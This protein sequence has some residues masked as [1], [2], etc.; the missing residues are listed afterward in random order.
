MML[1]R[2]VGPAAT[3]LCACRVLHAILRRR[4][5]PTV[6]LRYLKECELAAWV[7]HVTNCFPTTPANY[8]TSHLSCEPN[9][10]DFDS[11]HIADVPGEGIV[12][13]VRVLQ[14]EVYLGRGDADNQVANAG[15]IAEVSTLP[16]HRG[17]GYARRLLEKSVSDMGRAS[18]TISSLHSSKYAGYYEKL[19]WKRAETRF[20]FFTPN[21]HASNRAAALG[22]A[23]AG[24]DN[25]DDEDDGHAKNSRNSR[26]MHRS[27]SS[28]LIGP[29]RRKDEYWRRWLWPQLGS[30]LGL[31]DDDATEAVALAYR[32]KKEQ[33]NQR[34][35]GYVFFS[36]KRKKGTPPPSP[37]APAAHPR[38]TRQ[39]DIIIIAE[40]GADAKEV[41]YD[42]AQRERWVIANANNKAHERIQIKC[43]RHGGEIGS[44][45][46]CF[47]ALATA[48][49]VRKRAV[50]RVPEGIPALFRPR[51]PS[52]EQQSRGWER[53]EYV[54]RGYMYRSVNGTRGDDA[55]RH[56]ESLTARDSH[57]TFWVPDKF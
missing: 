20:L 23:A 41:E 47:E 21:T 9:G 17:K 55:Q 51:I 52:D 29:H 15:G 5:G 25:D 45:G 4:C 30:S 36:M 12:S 53:C 22:A 28:Q 56:L 18:M 7:Q 24:G 19:G 1:R 8:F 16:G 57:H 54:D 43:F 44:K 49:F 42:G 50:L 48:I 6:C 13:T 32:D 2:V 46:D 27:Y 10:V 3:L 34:P 38:E 37:P 35:C 39:T 33:L 26:E 11:I 31:G 14:R 40:F